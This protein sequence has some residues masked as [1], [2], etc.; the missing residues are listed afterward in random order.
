MPRTRNPD[1]DDM[2]NF[3]F[4][5]GE[6]EKS[7]EE[8]LT[9]WNTEGLDEDEPKPAVADAGKIPE[10]KEAAL[11]PDEVVT[12]EEEEG[13]DDEDDWDDEEEDDEDDET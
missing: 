8:L 7:D 12:D 13:S 3:H 9:E 1:Q 6:N 4:D 11:D 5:D 2:D 10:E